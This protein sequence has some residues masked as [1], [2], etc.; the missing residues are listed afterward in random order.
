MG[1][2]WDCY[3]TSEEQ[4]LFCYMIREFQLFP[5]LVH[6]TRRCDWAAPKGAPMARRPS[7]VT[8]FPVGSSVYA[9]CDKQPQI[10]RSDTQA[11]IQT[12]PLG[13]AQVNG[14][15]RGSET[16]GST[17]NPLLHAA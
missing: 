11:G 15:K 14:F 2:P 7:P 4:Q 5:Y 17:P 1:L 13:G 8:K 16:H 9:T 6:E 10:R 3:P 12:F